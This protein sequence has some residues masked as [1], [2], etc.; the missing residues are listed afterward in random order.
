[1][2]PKIK[3][4]LYATDLSKNSAYVFSYALNS[5]EMH[6]AK[7]DILYVSQYTGFTSPEGF[8]VI[9]QEDKNVILKKI[10]KRLDDFVQKELKDN[11]DM[12]KHVSSSKVVEGDPT[13]EILQMV[14]KLKPD[15]L[16]MGTHSKGAIALTFLGSVATKVMQHIRIPVF[17]IP[18]PKG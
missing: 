5:A 9:D 11:P 14:D 17:I 1:M 18:L 8:V 10:K 13:V 3:K 16:I 6:N 4:I 2:I 7:I 15:V 12:I